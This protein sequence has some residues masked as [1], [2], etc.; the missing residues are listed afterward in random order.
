L[1]AHDREATPTPEAALLWNVCIFSFIFSNHAR[2]LKNALRPSA[3]LSPLKASFDFDVEFFEAE[4]VYLF[5][6]STTPERFPIGVF[7]L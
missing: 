1:R 3:V 2:R 7:F 4:L 6:G 5:F